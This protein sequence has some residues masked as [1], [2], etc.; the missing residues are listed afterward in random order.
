MSIRVKRLVTIP[1]NTII[2]RSPTL[3]KS[4]WHKNEEH[5]KCELCETKFTFLIHKHHCRNCGRVICTKCQTTY[6]NVRGGLPI[7]VCELCLNCAINGEKDSEDCKT[8][9]DLMN[10]TDRKFIPTDFSFNGVKADVNDTLTI[11]KEAGH[12]IIT[13]KVISLETTDTPECI[14]ATDVNEGGPKIKLELLKKPDGYTT[15]KVGDNFYL[16]NLA[17]NSEELTSS[18]KSRILMKQTMNL[19]DDG[20]DDGLRGF[21]EVQKVEKNVQSGG[22]KYSKRKSKRSVKRRVSKSS[23]VRCKKVTK[24]LRKS[25]RRRIRR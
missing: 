18:V 2:D 4:Q 10:L 15:M 13:A 21:V 14:D 22:Y 8:Y 7:L 19:E 17:D 16:V 12:Y 20:L 6:K 25:R 9:M 11:I 24:R 23:T 1:F 3:H 5:T